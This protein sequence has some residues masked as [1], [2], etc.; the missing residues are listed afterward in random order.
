MRLKLINEHWSDITGDNERGCTMSELAIRVGDINLTE[1][2][3]SWS[4]TVDETVV[5]SAFPLSMW[6][7]ENWWRLLCEPLPGYL[8]GRLNV[9]WRMAHEMGAANE[10]FVWPAIAFVSD[11]EN[12]HIFARPSGDKKQS[13]RYINGLNHPEAVSVASFEGG[14]ERFVTEVVNRLKSLKMRGGAIEELWKIIA[15]ER[16]DPETALYRRI[17][18]SMGYDPDEAEEA[19]MRYAIEKQA[20]TGSGSLSELAPLYGKYSNDSLLGIEKLIDS[21]SVAGKPEIS[22]PRRDHGASRKSTPWKEAFRDAQLL[23]KEIS[24]DREPLD[25]DILFNLLGISSNDK[26][27]WERIGE[28]RRVSVGIPER[29]GGSFKFI[30]RKRHPLGRRFELARYLGDFFY[31]T[32]KQWLVGS[33]LGTVRQK[34]QRAFAAELLCPAEGL[35]EYLGYDF[36]RENLEDAAEHFR[37]SEFV[38]ESTLMNSG[39][40]KDTGSMEVPYSFHD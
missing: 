35:L 3:N 37:V 1:N 16:S 7:L 6:L 19:L 15:Q 36:S 8:G 25:T 31:T 26:N 14:V 30:P 17:E 40:M 2:Y 38:V 28:K 5:V 20:E 33:D 12:I 13:V 34:Y 18:A 24:K 9:D 11:Y 23:R 39:Y 4:K 27:R 10:G 29:D 22:L 32:D 21:S